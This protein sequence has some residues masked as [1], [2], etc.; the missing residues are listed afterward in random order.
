MFEINNTTKADIK[1]AGII[2]KP[3]ITKQTT[4][5]AAQRAQIERCDELTVLVVEP[6]S[7]TSKEDSKK[8]AK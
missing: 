8:G 7:N 3:G 4:L 5:S 1:R 2:F 6:T